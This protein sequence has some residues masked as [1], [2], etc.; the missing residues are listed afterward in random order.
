MLG[1]A[2]VLANGDPPSPELLR[3]CREGAG[4]FVVTD[5]ALTAA[6]QAGLTPDA[7]VGD[8]DSVPAE[9]PAGVERLP[10]AE[11]DTCDLEKALYTCVDRHY[12]A[13]TVLGAGGRRWD[14][15]HHHFGLFARYAMQ[16]RIEAGDAH[17]WL[18]MLRPGETWQTARRVGAKLSLLPLPVAS[19]V[20]VSGLRWTPQPQIALT[21]A[22]GLSNEV[23]TTLVTVRFTEGAL[24]VYDVTAGA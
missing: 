17:G 1:R 2:L 8:W 21:G 5:G 6:L 18:T 10:I 13:V 24:A 22:T 15:V 11:Q 19:G 3:C 14:M 9:V 16:L 23:V 20:E 4:W 7:V 12:E